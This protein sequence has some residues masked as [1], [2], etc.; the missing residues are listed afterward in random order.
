MIRLAI[1]DDHASYRDALAFML[2]HEPDIAVVAQAGS[3][4]EACQTVATAAIDV[5]LVDLELSDASGLDLLTA[6]HP[7]TAALLL[8]GKTE[9]HWRAVAAAAGAVGIL[10]KM[11]GTEE[12]LA[13]IRQAAAGMSMFTDAESEQLCS[14][15]TTHLAQMRADQQAL[16][17]LT[18]R[19]REVLCALI[20]GCNNQAIA[21]RLCLTTSTVR[22]HVNQV[23]R[24]L[25]VES[26]LQAALLGMRHQI[27]DVNA[28]SA[29]R[30]A[31]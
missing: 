22:T 13:A 29:E 4:A 3:L 11:V 1:I 9:P 26:R 14:H 27:S 24:K 15:G 6:L 8:T 20:A 12:I 16:A 21:D 23:L 30:E 28:H 18:R 5:A 7:R 2:D 17:Q 19:E 31:L 10:S 25:G